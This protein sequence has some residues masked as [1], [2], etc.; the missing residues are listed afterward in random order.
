M[1]LPTVTARERM[2]KNIRKALIEKRDNPWPELDP[3]PLYKEDLQGNEIMFAEELTRVGGNFIYCDSEINLVESLVSLVQNHQWK[4]LAA[5][6]P[7]LLAF[8]DEFEFP[9]T[10]GPSAVLD[11]AGSVTLCDAL[12]ARNGSVLIS[13]GVVSGRQ[14]MIFPPVHIVIAHSSQLVTDIKDGLQLVSK[15]YKHI[16]SSITL[17]TGP[18]RTADIEKTL[19][20]G[21]HGPKEL[22]VF[23]LDTEERFIF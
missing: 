4:N 2:L 6:D 7:G 5:G 22:Y 15:K 21:A 3:T 23:F 16:P 17:I 10:S 9:Y 1:S 13:T 19:V 8:L 20:L 14:L 12:V 18:S 11:A